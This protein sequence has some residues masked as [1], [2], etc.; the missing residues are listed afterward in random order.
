MIHI[1]NNKTNG[2]VILTGLCKILRL[3]VIKLIM[4]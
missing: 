4:F 3:Y 2:S 1:R